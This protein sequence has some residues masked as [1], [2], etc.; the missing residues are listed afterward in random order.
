MKLFRSGKADPIQSRSQELSA[1]IQALE[2][3][4]QELGSSLGAGE[5]AARGG[6]ATA[7]TF[8]GPNPFLSSPEAPTLD[9]A[10][11]ALEPVDHRRITVTAEPSP[12]AEAE[13]L[14]HDLG[15]RRF[16][17][18]SVA[19]RLQKHFHGPSANNP[20]LISYLAAGS[21]QGLRPLRYEKRVARN[22]VIAL[23][24][25]LGTILWGIFYMLWRQ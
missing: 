16:S 21:I 13:Q 7:T 10:E 5:S 17:V 9:G 22:R 4:I 14:R 2:A 3:Q 11:P 19:K 24:M 12:A 8:P 1:E 18:Q 6:T 23:T 25:V 15:Q 20:K